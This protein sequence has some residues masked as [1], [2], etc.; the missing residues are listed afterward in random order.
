MFCQIFIETGEYYE[1]D[2][3]DYRFDVYKET[4]GP[5]CLQLTVFCLAFVLCGI[6]FVWFCPL[7]LCLTL[8]SH[9]V[10]VILEW[11]RRL[12]SGNSKAFFIW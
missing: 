6:V 1:D 10:S 3:D 11:S 7:H 12:H 8:V 4:E 2:D 9:S 5:L